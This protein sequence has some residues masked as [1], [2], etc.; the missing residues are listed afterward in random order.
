MKK[1]AEI[2]LN[3]AKE[4]LQ[5]S[6]I[7]FES[8]LYNPCLQNAQQSIEKALKAILILKR[9]PVKKTHDVFE[10]N[11]KLLK[12]NV[13]I[14]IS[15]DECD[16]INSIYLPS[17]YPLGSVLPDFDP[18]EQICLQV[19]NIARRVFQQAKIILDS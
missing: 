14:D 2:W 15:E 8:N 10:L 13:A 9:I 17:K 7:L 5:S 11:Q 19:L 1:E 6:E 12:G 4:N 18:D 16:L 3:Y